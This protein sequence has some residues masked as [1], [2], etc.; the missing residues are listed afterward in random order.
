MGMD[1]RLAQLRKDRKLSRSAVARR[2]ELDESTVY[3]WEVGRRRPNADNL[4]ALALLYGLP[5]SS[6]LDAAKAD[7]QRNLAVTDD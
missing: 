4:L 3:L 7:Y 1:G 2:L 6:V 5:A